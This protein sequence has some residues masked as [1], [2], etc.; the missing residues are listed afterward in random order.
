VEGLS[1]LIL[2]IEEFFE[3]VVGVDV[4]L[5]GRDVRRFDQNAR[6]VALQFVLSPLDLMLSKERASVVNI[7]NA[8][9]I[10]YGF[11]I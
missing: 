7:A 8:H 10:S 6:F 3:R 2:E 5:C 4:P 1:I 9:D 11:L